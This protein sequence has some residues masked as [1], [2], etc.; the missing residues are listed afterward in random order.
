MCYMMPLVNDVE[1]VG[2]TKTMEY[3]TNKQVSINERHLI[4]VNTVLNI[5][6]KRRQGRLG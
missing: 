4:R 5:V 3:L 6:M 2:N 1:R